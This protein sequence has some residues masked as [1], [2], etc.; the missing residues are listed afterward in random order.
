M[1]NQS[2]SWDVTFVFL[3]S[4]N[5]FVTFSHQ[6][7]FQVILEMD[8]YFFRSEAIINQWLIG[9]LGPGSWIPRNI[10][11]ERNCYLR[12]PGYWI[13]NHRALGQLLPTTVDGSEIRRSPVNMVNIP[14]C[15]RVSWSFIHVGWL[16]LISS[17]N[18]IYNIFWNYVST[19]DRWNFSDGTYKDPKYDP[20]GV[21]RYRH[22]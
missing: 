5:D 13:P 11:I 8:S 3:Q 20:L 2:I 22:P 16:R 17:I 4:A 12:T 14:L 18:S 7:C 10:P 6:F 19:Q 9:G 1:L 15:T 21:Y